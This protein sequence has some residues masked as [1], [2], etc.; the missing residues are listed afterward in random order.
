VRAIAVDNSASRLEFVISMMC[1]MKDRSSLPALEGLSAHP[2]HFVRWAAVQAL[3]RLDR[4]R[5]I[6]A[7]RN[8][9]ADRHEHVRNAASRSLAKIAA[10]TDLKGAPGQIHES[11]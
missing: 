11:P 1:V 7:L 2:A 8:A 5:G 10:N 6:T 9:L 3:F 4:E